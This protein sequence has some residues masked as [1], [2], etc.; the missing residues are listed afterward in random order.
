L[1]TKSAG[2]FRASEASSD[3]RSFGFLIMGPFLE[4]A[5]LLAP[6]FGE[7]CFASC[8]YGCHIQRAT[9]NTSGICQT[10]YL[11]VDKA[12]GRI[13]HLRQQAAA[14]QDASLEC[15]SLLAPWFGEACFASCDYGC[16]IQRATGNNSG[17]CQTP[18]LNV[19]RAAGRIWHLRQQ[20]AASQD[21]SLECVSLLLP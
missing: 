19:D 17:I 11:N 9:G 16:H 2:S 7:A 12:A 14:S 18:Y 4:C 8:D 15:A 10:P 6:W 21:A 5:S 13:W 20:A 1:R 3:L